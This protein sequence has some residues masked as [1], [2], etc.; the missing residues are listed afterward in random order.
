MVSNAS[1]WTCGYSTVKDSI[2][3]LEYDDGR[4]YEVVRWLEDELENPGVSDAVE[5]AK[6]LA[7]E[8]PEELIRRIHDSVA[9]WESIRENREWD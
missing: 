1:V 2:T 3:I 4:R 8:D 9:H 7:K 5:N 6:R